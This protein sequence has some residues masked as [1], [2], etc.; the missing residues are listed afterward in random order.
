M[1]KEF[2]VEN[3]DQEVL[4]NSGVTVVDF[5]AE[6]C[7][8]CRVFTP[9]V[10]QLSEKMAGRASVGKLNVD[11]NSDIASDSGI[12]GIPTVIIYKG[13]KEVQR[14]SGVIQLA[15]LEKMVEQAINL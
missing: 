2:N 10:E 1:A 13:G 7:G 9:I 14:K 6:W 12:R 8:P 15:E 5:W 4:K 3:W 11:Q